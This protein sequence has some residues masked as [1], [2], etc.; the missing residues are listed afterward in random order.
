MTNLRVLLIL[1][2]DSVAPTLSPP[3]LR[4]QSPQSG[5]FVTPVTN[6]RFLSILTHNPVAPTPPPPKLRGLCG[7]GVAL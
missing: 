1:T 2:D 4:G 3:K 6:L 7:N 5:H